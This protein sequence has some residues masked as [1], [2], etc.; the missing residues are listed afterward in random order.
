MES[1]IKINFDVQISP[2]GTFN[3]QENLGSNIVPDSKIEESTFLPSN[4]LATVV[5]TSSPAKVIDF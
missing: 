5:I 1:S 4:T 3:F 2:N